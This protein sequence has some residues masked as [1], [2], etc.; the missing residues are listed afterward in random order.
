MPATVE[1]EKKA[2]PTKRQQ[3]RGTKPHQA[4]GTKPNQASNAKKFWARKQRALEK[5]REVKAKLAYLRGQGVHFNKQEKYFSCD[6]CISMELGFSNNLDKALAHC[7]MQ[8]H[9]INRDQKL[10]QRHNRGSQ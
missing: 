6:N 7:N 8:G 1:E 5:E 4:R 10:K 3:A 9:Q 2:A